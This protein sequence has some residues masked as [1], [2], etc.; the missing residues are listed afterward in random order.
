MNEYQEQTIQAAREIADN[1]VESQK[2]IINSFQLA[3]LPQIE[4]VN[5]VINA[6]WVS[7]RHFADNYAKVVSTLAD[8]TMVA[9]RL[10][11]NTIFAT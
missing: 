8:N 4:T 1:F 6:S 5:K 7:P 3:W 10:V 2:E 9:T 11:N